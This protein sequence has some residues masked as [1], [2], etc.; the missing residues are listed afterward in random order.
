MLQTR[1]KE[2][3]NAAKI[4]P[5]AVLQGP[6]DVSGLSRLLKDA[7]YPVVEILNRS[8]YTWQALAQIREESPDLLVGVGT[9]L[10]IDEMRRAAAGGASFAVSPGWDPDLWEEAERLGLPY[11]PGVSSPS[12]VQQLVKRGAVLAKFFPAAALGTAYLE[13]MAAAYPQIRF[14]VSGGL[15]ANNWHEFLDLPPVIAIGGSWMLPKNYGFDPDHSGLVAVLKTLR[16]RA[17]YQGS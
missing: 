17:N 14:T 6:E 1:L 11:L 16:T 15:G 8:P 5:A 13:Q 12:E 3:M 10:S 4:I 9:I 7:A 2:A